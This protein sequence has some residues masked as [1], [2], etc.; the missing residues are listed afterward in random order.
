MNGDNK[1]GLNAKKLPTKLTTLRAQLAVIH[2]RVGLHYAL[3]FRMANVRNFKGGSL[4]TFRP[5]KRQLIVV[6]LWAKKGNMENYQGHNNA[7]EV[8]PFDPIKEQKA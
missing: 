7:V 3:R 5:S 4:I 1:Y 8:S 6:Q 2:I